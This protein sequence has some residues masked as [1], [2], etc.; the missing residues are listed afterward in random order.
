MMSGRDKL[1]MAQESQ[2]SQPAPCI[3]NSPEGAPKWFSSN[4]QIKGFGGGVP[5][6]TETA[7]VK[8]RVGIEEITKR[9][10]FFVEMAGAGGAVTLPAHLISAV[11]I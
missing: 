4:L 10:L 5:P 1:K 3:Y 6:N 9:C 11:V 7:A 2:C 8:P